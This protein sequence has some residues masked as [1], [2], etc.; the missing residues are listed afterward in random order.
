MCM[1]LPCN[2]FQSPLFRIPLS[3][4]FLLLFMLVEDLGNKIQGLVLI[5]DVVSEEEEEFL[6]NEVNKQVWSGLGIG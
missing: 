4:S 5:K 6:V 1:C 3:F 2:F